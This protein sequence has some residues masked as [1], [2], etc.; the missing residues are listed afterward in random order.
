MNFST[1]PT[2]PII[3]SFDFLNVS[4]DMIHI[5]RTNT[6]LIEKFQLPE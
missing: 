4:L 2:V 1:V 5:P 3:F 6:E